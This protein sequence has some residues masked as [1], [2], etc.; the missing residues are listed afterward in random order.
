MRERERER[1]RMEQSEQVKR[2]M[3]GRDRRGEETVSEQ[4]SKREREWSRASK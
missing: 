1:E 4:A 2:E 3:E